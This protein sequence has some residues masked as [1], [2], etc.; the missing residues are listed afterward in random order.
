MNLTIIIAINEVSRFPLLRISGISVMVAVSDPVLDK[1]FGVG[2]SEGTDKRGGIIVFCGREDG[3]LSYGGVC[4][5]TPNHA[6]HI[7]V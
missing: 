6:A 3:E 7:I 5:V 2:G 4:Y 1:F